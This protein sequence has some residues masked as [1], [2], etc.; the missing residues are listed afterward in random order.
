MTGVDLLAQAAPG[1]LLAQLVAGGAGGNLAA[2]AL[3]NF[4]LGVIWNSLAGFIGGAVGA[5]LLFNIGVMPQSLSDAEALRNAILAGAIGGIT[6]FVLLGLI[7][8]ML[9]R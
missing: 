9:V 5:Q 1:H 8:S 3:R 6:L 2:V 4:S 7:K